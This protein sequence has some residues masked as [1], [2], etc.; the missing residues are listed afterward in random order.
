M[1]LK[2]PRGI[3]SKL[4]GN[5]QGAQ[6]LLRLLVARDH[7]RVVHV[8]SAH[9]LEEAI[10]VAR[11]ASVPKGKFVFRRSQAERANHHRRQRVGELALEHRALAR[12]NSVILPHLSGQEGR[13]DIGEINLSRALEVA[14]GA[15]ETLRHYA[16]IDI[17]GAEHVPHLPQ[18]FLDAH[19]RSGVA[20]TVVA[21]KEQPQFF[22]GHPATPQAKCPGQSPDF[23][24]RAHPGNKQKIRHARAPPTAA[25]FSGRSVAGHGFAGYRNLFSRLNLRRG[26]AYDENLAGGSPSSCTT[27]E[28]SNTVFH[29]KYGQN[30]FRSDAP[31]PTAPFRLESQFTVL[32]NGPPIQGQ[33]AGRRQPPTSASALVNSL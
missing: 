8:A 11:F 20:R 22:A 2:R 19:V 1:R 27:R 32:E 9:F 16:E 13:K 10:H 12:D 29:F 21:R 28:L 4:C 25:D 5:P 18:H 14:A 24:E 23:D 15:V 33:Y 31:C 17:C 6:Q 30:T 3:R 7:Q 26:N